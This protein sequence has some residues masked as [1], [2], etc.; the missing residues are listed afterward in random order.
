L[1][2]EYYLII[3][4]K[5]KVTKNKIIFGG[6]DGPQKIEIRYAG[7]WPSLSFSLSRAAQGFPHSPPSLHWLYLQI[8]PLALALA[9]PIV[10]R[11][12][13]RQLWR[14]QHRLVNMAVQVVVGG[15]PEVSS[16]ARRSTHAEVLV[17]NP[18]RSQELLSHHP[19]W[20]RQSLIKQQLLISSSYRTEGTQ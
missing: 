10:A 12:H 8:H 5:K 15:A 13:Q 17:C 6:L 4:S 3:S 16:A 1:T 18:C 7:G 20:T 2:A 9:A 19:P 11:A 14:G